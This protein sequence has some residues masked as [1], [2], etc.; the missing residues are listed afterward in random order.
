MGSSQRHG[1][2]H[3]QS[4]SLASLLPLSIDERIIAYA[5]FDL[6]IGT[7]ISADLSRVRRVI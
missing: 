7:D 6:E 5:L 3:T 2:P 4:T 1:S